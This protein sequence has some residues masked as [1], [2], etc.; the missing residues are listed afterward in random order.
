MTRRMAQPYILGLCLAVLCACNIVLVCVI[1][2]WVGTFRVQ[3]QTLYSLRDQNARLLGQL[4]RAMQRDRV[5][6]DVLRE[7]GIELRIVEQPAPSDHGL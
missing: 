4:T 1:R 3:Q 7:N 2:S 6:M 5:I